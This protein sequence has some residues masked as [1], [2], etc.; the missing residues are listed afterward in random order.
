MCFDRD[1]WRKEYTAEHDFLKPYKGNRRKDMSESQQYKY[2]RF[3]AHLVEFENLIINHT[4]IITLY[5]ERLEADDLIAGF[6]QHKPE[7]NIII[8]SADSDLA[9]LMKYNNVQLIS[10]AT[11]KKQTTLE[12]FENDPEYYLFHKCIRGDITDNVQSAYPRVRSTKIK[13]VYENAM[14]GD[15]YKYINFMKEKWI[16]QNKR[17]FTVAEMFTHNQALIDLEKQPKDIRQIMENTLLEELELKKQFSYFH[18]LKFIGKYKLDK[19]RD[20]IDMFVPMLSS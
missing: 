17:V 15:G 19:I 9:Q 20:N 12:K 10:P 6:V 3:K 8:I 4:T 5:G 1:S 13:E 2:A 14:E 18:I 16:D 11:D 7:N